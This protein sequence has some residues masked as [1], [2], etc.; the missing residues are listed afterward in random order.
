M[1]SGTARTPVSVTVT[2]VRPRLLSTSAARSGLDGLDLGHRPGPGADIAD[3]PL[4]HQSALAHHA[5]VGADLLDLREQ[6]AG[7]EDGGPVGRQRGDQRP[8]LPSALR[9]EAVRRLVQQQQVAGR[10]QRRG[11]R[12]PLAHPE[13]V[14][15]VALACRGE[16]P[17]PLQRRID[18][19]AG[20]RRV[21]MA[22]RRVQPGEIRAAGQVGMEGRSLDQR[23]HPRQHGAGPPGDGLA[24]DLDPPLR[25][26]D[27]PEEHADGRGLAGSVRAEEAVHR[28]LRNVEIDAVDRRLAPEALGEAGRGDGRRGH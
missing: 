13:G 22:I 18:P 2:S 17:H 26:M 27:Q 21:G 4:R 14:G 23:P 3:G 10:E 1:P 25:G 20:R 8:H 7:D 28:S 15:A 12:E 6:V 19:R 16:Q 9:V 11:D 5:E 24:E